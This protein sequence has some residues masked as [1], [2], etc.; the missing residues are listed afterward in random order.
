MNTIICHSVGSGGKNDPKDVRRV[1]QLLNQQGTKPKLVVDGRIGPKT[2]QAIRDFQALFMQRPDGRVDVRGT[3]LRK[4]NQENF[5][6]QSALAAKKPATELPESRPEWSGDSSQ[7]TSEKKLQSMN[8]QFRQ[9]V[10]NVIAVLEEKN[11][12][13]RIFFGW[14]SIQVQAELKRQGRTR[15]DFSFHNAQKKDGTP[16]AYAADII[17]RRWAWGQSAEDNGFWIALGEAAKTAGLYWGGDWT[18]FK[19]V[20]H[21]QYYPNSMLSQIR[22]ESGF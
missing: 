1:Q 10:K 6:R 9:K 15:V 3:T 22:Q 20:A 7:W 17:D 5:Q 4:L 12:R 11:F 13:P 14:R 8:P 18:S 21:I 19:D 2:I 16:N